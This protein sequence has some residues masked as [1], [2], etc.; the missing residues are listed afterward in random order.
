MTGQTDTFCDDLHTRMIAG[1]TG[2]VADLMTHFRSRLLKI[3]SFRM[4]RRLHGRVDPDDVLQDAFVDAAKRMKHYSADKQFSPFVWIR[5]IVQQTLIDTHRRHL[6]ALQRDASREQQKATATSISVA[7]FLAANLTSVSRVAIREEE[8]RSLRDAVETMETIDR[9][10]L[11]LRH[12][13]G[14]SNQ[15]VAEV[16]EITQKTAS[17]RY[18]RALVRLKAILG[19]LPAFRPLTDRL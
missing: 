18:V 8:H 15:E 11:A 1:D 7:D 2:A 13:E 10:V 6:G 14:L 5:L 12:F 4:D 3:I 19:Q 17:I 9:E 16:L